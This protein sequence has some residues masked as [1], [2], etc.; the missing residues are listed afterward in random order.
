[1][2]EAVDRALREALAKWPTLNASPES[3]AAY[4]A[5]HVE[6]AAPEGLRDMVLVHACLAGDRGALRIFEHEVMHGVGAA[7]SR[8]ETSADAVDE[9][10]QQL[11][12]R[13]L[14]GEDA[15][16]RDF[17]GRGSLVGWVNVSAIRMALNQQRS[18]RRQERRLG[19]GASG[20]PLADLVLAADTL[21]VELELLKARFRGAFSDAVRGACRELGER[22]RTLL[23]MQ[24]L[25]GHGIDVIASLY[26]VHR[27]TAARWMHRAREALQNGA[28][29]R[30][31]AELGIST[32][33][34]RMVEKLLHTQLSVS[35]S[36]LD[37]AP[38]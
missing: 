13:L 21:D 9:L 17:R 14:T 25:E 12:T 32:V 18:A 31:S 1:M 28:R 23:K 36:G 38:K 10:K 19:A 3:F 26:D 20:D 8:I 15:K 33:D 30:L 11:R 35:F 5:D 2:S 29:S 6:S 37:D 22:D 34:A 24:L 7:V 4:A 16:L 27:S